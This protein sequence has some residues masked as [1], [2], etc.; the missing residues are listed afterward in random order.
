MNDADKGLLFRY[1]KE[2]GSCPLTRIN[3]RH[4]TDEWDDRKTYL[5]GPVED[6][7]SPRDRIGSRAFFDISNDLSE[8]ENKITKLGLLSI[9][10]QLLAYVPQY[11]YFHSEFGN[12]LNHVDKEEYFK[13]HYIVSQFPNKNKSSAMDIY[14]NTKNSLKWL[15][16]VETPEELYTL[17]KQLYGG[18]KKKDVAECSNSKVI[19]DIQQKRGICFGHYTRDD[20]EEIQIALYDSED[21][22]EGKLFEHFAELKYL[23]HLDYG[24]SDILTSSIKAMEA[25]VYFIR[26][27]KEKNSHS[28]GLF[29]GDEI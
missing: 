21:E 9:K 11:Q 2:L 25:L 14:Q 17:F 5:T 6:G 10:E 29:E 7:Y 23:K 18:L 22:Y 27:T 15:S 8:L 19:L 16:D 3:E 28:W 4:V 26:E 12:H 1:V 20:L 13:E 24:A